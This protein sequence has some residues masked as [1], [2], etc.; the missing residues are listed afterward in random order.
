MQS[1]SRAVAADIKIMIWFSLRNLPPE[2]P[3]GLMYSNFTPKPA[4]T[5]YQVVC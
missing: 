3:M 4:F 2:F 5:T 1:Y